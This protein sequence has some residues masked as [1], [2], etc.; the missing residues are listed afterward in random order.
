MA[1]FA[2]LSSKGV[3]YTPLGSVVWNSCPRPCRWF[4]RSI[5]LPQNLP[6]P[7]FC[8]H[9]YIASSSLL[10]WAVP[11]W[12]GFWVLLVWCSVTGSWLLPPAPY[13]WV[14][15]F[16]VLTWGRH[17]PTLG[18]DRLTELVLWWLGRHF[19]SEQSIGSPWFVPLPS[20]AC[21]CSIN[22][23]LCRFH[24]PANG[25]D[26]NIYLRYPVQ[27]FSFLLYPPT[28]PKK[29][30]PPRTFDFFWKGIPKIS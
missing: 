28:H 12:R 19:N 2:P 3:S 5:W 24:L 4:C 21:G 6:D 13:A 16:W 1:L 26:A 29:G 8:N 15:Q 11:P 7:I 22:K 30:K 25:I 10:G 20:Y 18:H 23:Y 14:L 17:L 27:D 9:Y